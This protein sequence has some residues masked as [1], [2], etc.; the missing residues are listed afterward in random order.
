MNCSPPGSSVHWDSPGKNTGLG[1]HS[2]LQGIFLTQGLNLSFPHC[3]QTL[4]FFKL[5]N[6]VLVL[7]NIEMDPPQVYMCSPSWT[8]LP[9]PSP[10]SL[11]LSHQERPWLGNIPLY[12]YIYQNFFIHSS[13]VRHL[14]CFHVLAILNSA[15]MN[16]RIHVSLGT[17]VFFRRKSKKGRRYVYIR[18]IHFAVQQK[19]TQRK[20]TMKWSVNL[21]VMSDFLWPYGPC[22]TQGSNPHLPCLLHCRQ[23]LYP[24]ATVEAPCIIIKY[25][26]C[27]CGHS[28]I[29]IHIYHMCVSKLKD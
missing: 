20:A 9:P 11:Q 23:I 27:T 29:H 12:M 7:P 28:S 8:L 17:M 25:N 26:V 6:I 13:I 2:L 10:Y 24:W 14:S 16:I 4:F 3:R 22:P 21:S 19:L 5:Y 1:C 18:L 15:A